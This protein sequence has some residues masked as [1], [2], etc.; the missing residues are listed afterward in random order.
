MEGKAEERIKTYLSA[1]KNLGIALF[2]RHK[3]FEDLCPR[4]GLEDDEDKLKVFRK[5]AVFNRE[6]R[7]LLREIEEVE[8]GSPPIGARAILPDAKIN[9]FV[10]SV[11]SYLV[12][13]RIYPTADNELSTVG[14]LAE[15]MGGKNP[16]NVLQIRNLFLDNE[17]GIL[18][19]IVHMKKGKIATLDDYYV[20]MKEE[21]F[22]RCIN[23]EPTFQQKALSILEG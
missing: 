23:S 22:A 13:C 9:D 4:I 5:I 14:E 11:I 1:C 12:L 20:K 6:I 15:C 10:R 21:V 3:Q 19:E 18:R 17:N 16:L 7:R 2:G 8:K